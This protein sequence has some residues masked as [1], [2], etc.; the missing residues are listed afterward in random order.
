M[1]VTIFKVYVP[2]NYF[3]WVMTS[4]GV[5]LLTT[6][7]VSSPVGAWVGYQIIEGIGFGIFYAAPQ[8]PVLA[9]V[10]IEVV[11]HFADE[12][13]IKQLPDVPW[14]VARGPP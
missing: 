13:D 9:P 6:L 2:Q 3:G 4:I 7:K 12:R 8:F 5:G 10:K 1:T 11:G 14:L